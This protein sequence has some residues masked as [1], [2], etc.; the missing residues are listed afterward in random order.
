MGTLFEDDALGHLMYWAQHDRKTVKK[1]QNLINDIQRNGL[2]KGIGHPEPLKYRPGWSRHI[3]H[4]NRLIYDTD[5]EGNLCIFS[6]KG[7]YE[8]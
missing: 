2:S 8:D 3:D 1:I 7:H 5:R 4:E 6:C